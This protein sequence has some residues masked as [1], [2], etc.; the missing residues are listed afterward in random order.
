M[1]FSASGLIV[2]MKKKSGFEMSFMFMLS[3]FFRG[4]LFIKQALKLLL[5][6]YIF[7]CNQKR[8]TDPL[9]CTID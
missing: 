1:S 3:N 9:K 4:R 2:E 8:L 5:E 6:A 7:L